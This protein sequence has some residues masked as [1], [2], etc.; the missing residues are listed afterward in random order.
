MMGQYMKAKVGAVLGLAWVLAACSLLVERGGEQ[1]SS[2]GDCASKGAAFAGMTCSADKICVKGSGV[3]EGGPDAPIDPDGGDSGDA[4]VGEC[5]TNQQCIDKNGGAAAICRKDTLGCVKLLNTDCDAVTSSA[6]TGTEL[7]GADAVRDDAT[8]VIGAVLPLT[9]AN[10]P[11]NLARVDA[12]VLAISEIMNRTAGLP[13][14]AGTTARRPV[15]V[16]RCNELDTVNPPPAK[17]APARAA[18]HL[19]SVGVP[20]VVGGGTSGTTVALTPLLAKKGVFLIAPSATSPSLTNADD[21]GLLWR[22]APSDALQSIPLADRIQNLAPDNGSKRVAILYKSDAYGQGLFGKAVTLVTRGGKAL[23]DPSNAAFAYLKQY[24]PAAADQSA[25]VAEILALNP[26]PD[27]ISILGTT[28]GITTLLT[29]I[30][31]GWGGG[32]RPQYVLSDGLKGAGITAAVTADEAGANTGLRGRVVGTA[33][34]RPTA[35][36]NAFYLRYE[37]KYGNSQ[38]RAFGTA[39]AY[40]AAYVIMY[41]IAATADKPVTG[42]NIAAGVAQLVGGSTIIDVGP[43]GVNDA[44]QK[45]SA[46]AKVD[47]NGASS[48]LNF[49]LAVGESPADIEVWCVSPNIPTATL[50]TSPLFFDAAQAK[51]SGAFSCP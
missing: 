46:A 47:L 45:L 15:A 11:R 2:D 18:E 21:D 35:T 24:D 34:G 25:I 13:P 51:M 1:C 37:P 32:A 26:R 8:I 20:A 36:T 14:A 30:E 19:L 6:A 10:G 43:D 17:L 41:G 33:P 49:D 29:P 3:N 28:E 42:K 44:F 9:G 23:S 31:A 12:I 48:P 50:S 4:F 16:L 7:K 39:G 27:V 38:S 22:T 40:D 5:T